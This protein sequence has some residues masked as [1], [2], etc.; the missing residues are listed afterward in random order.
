MLS[1]IIAQTVCTEQLLPPWTWFCS[2][3]LYPSVLSSPRSVQQSHGVLG[4]SVFCR[5]NSTANLRSLSVLWR[6]SPA[7]SQ[8][9]LLFPACHSPGTVS[10]HT[11]CTHVQGRDLFKTRVQPWAVHYPLDRCNWGYRVI[12]LPDWWQR[13]LTHFYFFLNKP[14]DAT[15]GG[16]SHNPSMA[17]VGHMSWA[18]G[19]L[20]TP[21]SLACQP[22][23]RSRVEKHRWCNH[24][25]DVTTSQMMIRLFSQ[26]S[27]WSRT[28]GNPT[29]EATEPHPNPDL[30]PARAKHKPSQLPMPMTA[31]RTH[32]SNTPWHCPEGACVQTEQQYNLT[33]VVKLSL[34]WEAGW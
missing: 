7:I 25:S 21:P 3:S 29:Q 23:N 12:S 28:P 11:D 4:L 6:L 2:H 13:R 20:L 1:T 10:T 24:F 5:F 18:V 31:G 14:L 22:H 16:Q 32:T 8:H 19:S 33:V 30:T 26:L 15:K 34:V 9:T 27:K 17:S